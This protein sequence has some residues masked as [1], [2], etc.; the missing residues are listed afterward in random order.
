MLLSPLYP[1]ALDQPVQWGH[2]TCSVLWLYHNQPEGPLHL[3]IILFY[4]CFALAKGHCTSPANVSCLFCPCLFMPIYLIMPV[5]LNSSVSLS[6]SFRALHHNRTPVH[7]PIHCYL[8]G[9]ASP[10]LAIPLPT[11]LNSAR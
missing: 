6:L 11:I 4:T 5:C 7:L 1:L 8:V 2:Y 10:P 9:P 3:V